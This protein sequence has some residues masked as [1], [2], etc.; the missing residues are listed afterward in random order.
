[1]AVCTFVTKT[2]WINILSAFVLTQAE[3][4][5]SL[6]KRRHHPAPEHHIIS[7]HITSHH[8]TSH[9]ITSHRIT[10]HHI[11][12][13]H[14]TPHT[15][16]HTHTLTNTHN[17]FVTVDHFTC[18]MYRITTKC[19]LTSSI[20]ILERPHATKT[21]FFQRRHQSCVRCRSVPRSS[22]PSFRGYRRRL[23]TD[24]SFL[25][26]SERLPWPSK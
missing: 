24:Q 21:M 9:H 1:M 7:H 6:H 17:T 5:T 18:F 20:A 8:I 4:D 13:H 3:D 10:S 25:P 26:S 23:W 16:T 19:F 11:T 22:R 15:H 2:D 14:T 12:S